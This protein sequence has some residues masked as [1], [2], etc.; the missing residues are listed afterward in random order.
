LAARRV[1]A[2]M[3]LRDSAI[4]AHARRWIVCLLVVVIVGE[5]VHLAVPLHWLG[6]EIRP[7]IDI[8]SVAHFLQ[9]HDVT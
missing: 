1:G 4:S 5:L 3:G 9:H 8:F 7:A 2:E 6:K